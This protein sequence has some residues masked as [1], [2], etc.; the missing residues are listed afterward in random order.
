LYLRPNAG[1]LAASPTPV[2]PF[3]IQDVKLGMKGKIEMLRGQNQYPD[4]TATGDKD[5]TF[6]FSMGRKDYFLLNQI[7]NADTVTVGGT[8]VA[9]D[10]NVTILATL[11]PTYPA[12]GTFAED[13][14]VT[15]FKPGA[16]T[17]IQMPLGSSTPAAGSYYQTGG[18]YSF[19][20]AD[21]TTGGTVTIACSYTQTTIGSTFQVNNQG[22]GFGP[23]F[24]AFIVDQ[25]QPVM[26]SSIPIYSAIRLYAAKISDV[27]MDNKRSGYATCSLKGS[28]YASANGRVIDLYS[29]V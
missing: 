5:G 17:P 13:L 8:S 1:N 23:A 10:S 26:S 20:A 18:A 28:Y 19:N 14:G 6:E 7:F 16:T 27:E 11:T 22:Q 3:T 4:D 21:V 9:L 15:W 2:K 29:N 12:S 24:E 25:Y